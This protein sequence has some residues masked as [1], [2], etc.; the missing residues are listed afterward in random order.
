MRSSQTDR[1][2][3]DG[4][5]ILPHSAA[6]HLRAAMKQM[7]LLLA[8]GQTEEGLNHLLDL[9]HHLRAFRWMIA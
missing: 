2:R 3:R 1:T 6:L 8:A 9:L 4:A 5:I 7:D